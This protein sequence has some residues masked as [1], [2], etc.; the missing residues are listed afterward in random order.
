MLTQ[1]LGTS[2]LSTVLTPSNSV[3]TL[4]KATLVS[5]DENNASKVMEPFHFRL[6]AFERW[7]GAAN[8]QNHITFLQITDVALMQ[9]LKIL[10]EMENILTKVSTNENANRLLALREMLYQLQPSYLG[11]PLFDHN[12]NLRYLNRNLKR[13]FKIKNLNVLSSKQYEEFLT[14]Y[15]Y[16]ELKLVPVCIKLPANASP[17]TLIRVIN[18]S[19][20]QYGI[21]ISASLKDLHTDNAT[22][23][24]CDE[25]IWH[26]FQQ[27]LL[28]S[29][30]GQR[31]PAG[32]PRHF[33]VEEV[34]SWQS[35][36]EWKLNE[37]SERNASLDKIKKTIRKLE[38][39]YAWCR[40][41]Q[42]LFKK[43][44]NFK[45][46]K[47]EDSLRK[48]SQQMKNGRFSKRLNAIVAQANI[49]VKQSIELLES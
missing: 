23:F 49:S 4:Q 29:G 36:M 37:Y 24:V 21:G 33:K 34:L 45:K 20:Q 1:R 32:E 25:L 17:E 46:Q 11:I 7:A 12:L 38:K 18:Q 42:N 3:A 48:L 9:G 2:N 27:G 10:R 16:H 43:K 44:I 5:F 22:I 13:K 30:Q 28:L 35:P 26:K 31:I 6:S 19:L 47:T 14:I 39:Q 40:N 41:E 15:V 8:I